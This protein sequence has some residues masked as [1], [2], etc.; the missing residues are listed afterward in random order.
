MNSQKWSFMYSIYF[1]LSLPSSCASSLSALLFSSPVLSCPLLLFPPSLCLP[2]SLFY[3]SPPSSFIT[4]IPKAWS[5]FWLQSL[6]KPLAGFQEKGYQ[7]TSYVV[8]L[9]LAYNNSVNNLLTWNWNFSICA[10]KTSTEL[11]F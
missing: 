8:L 2:L 7:D 10:S 1:F 3:L 9:H 5:L 11:K 4:D 6:F